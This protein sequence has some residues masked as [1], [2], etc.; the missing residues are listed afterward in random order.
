MNAPTPAP[1]LA[2][3]LQA[4]LAP[5]PHFAD[6]CAGY[7]CWDPA[8]GY[9]PRGYLGATGRVGE[10]RLVLATAE[11]GEPDDGEAYAGTPRAMLEAVAARSLAAFER[12]PRANS[13]PAPFHR[14]LRKIL[15][16]CWPGDSLQD[17]LV[18]TWIAPAVLCT[19]PVFGMPIPRVMETTCARAYF[20]Q[21]IEALGDVYIVALGAKAHA[22][23]ER[24]GVTAAFI[25]QHPSA[26]PITKPEASW[27]A[28]GAAFRS[29][30]TER[31]PV[32]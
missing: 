21:T 19:T 20:R 31:T 2:E 23:L 9:V 11:P 8:R 22:R 15:D 25:A 27:A 12:G 4:A 32:F 30:L 29:W 16:F 28:S 10:V 17:Q 5:C 18:K 14:N 26:R 3:I 1:E 7:A 24:G 13:A 6:V